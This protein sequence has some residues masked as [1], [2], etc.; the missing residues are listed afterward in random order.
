MRKAATV[1][2][3]GLHQFGEFVVG[4]P[5]STTPN[6]VRCEVEGVVDTFRPRLSL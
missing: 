6:Y 2:S 4:Q 5:I 1:G 3:D